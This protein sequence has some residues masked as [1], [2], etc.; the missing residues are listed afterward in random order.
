MAIVKIHVWFA[1]V[2]TKGLAEPATSLGAVSAPRP[3]K[4]TPKD[5]THL[6]AVCATSGQLDHFAALA[7]Q[8]LGEQPA[9]RKGRRVFCH[10]VVFHVRGTKW[11]PAARPMGP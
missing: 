2:P 4:G 10:N 3:S 9:L 5:G 8:Q 6:P 7:L 11:F 1:M